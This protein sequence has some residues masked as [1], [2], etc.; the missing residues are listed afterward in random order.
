VINDEGRRFVVLSFDTPNDGARAFYG[1]L[2]FTES[3]RQLRSEV[4][5]LLQPPSTDIANPS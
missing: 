5:R 3:A 2:G 1:R 4:D